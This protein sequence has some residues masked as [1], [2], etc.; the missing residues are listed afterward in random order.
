MELPEPTAAMNEQEQHQSDELGFQTDEPTIT[1]Q[2]QALSVQPQEEEGDCNGSEEGESSEE[3]EITCDDDAQQSWRS[4]DSGGHQS[5]EKQQSG[6]EIA[7]EENEDASGNGDGDRGENGEGRGVEVRAGKKVARKETSR[8]YQFPVRP[9]AE[10]C[11][12]YVRTGTCKFGMNCKFNHPPKRKPLSVKTKQKAKDDSSEKAAK[13]NCK[14]HDQPGGCKSGEA[15]KDK[16][17]SLNF[18]G[19]PIRPGE[20]DCPYYMQNGSCKFGLSCRFNHPDPA[21][22]EK[23]D[24]LPVYSNGGPL[25]SQGGPQSPLASWS[26]PLAM[27]DTTSYMPSLFPPNQGIPSN[28][29]WNNYQAP[30]YP[31]ER[32]VPMSPAYTVN[33]PVLEANIYAQQKQMPVD[34]FPKRP[35]Q[36]NCHYYLRT[37]D[38]KFKSV[39]KFH[40]PKKKVSKSAKSAKCPLNDLGLPLRPGKSI[41]SHYSRYGICK[42]GPACNKDHPENYAHTETSAAS[43]LNEPPS[44]GNSMNADDVIG[45]GI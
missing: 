41:C 45:V 15:C 5:D 39:C 44:V 9:E 43:E 16:H 1:D 3:E 26:P 23:S 27:N 19:L 17:F 10:K 11:A 25:A 18:L 21:A 33:S 14:N 7:T 13:V 12:F 2:L 20:K 42:F 29:E 28:P 31:Y 8:P 38:C 35:G 22:S 4:D 40:H 32:S 36:P 24:T 37:G 6:G 30:F 34:E